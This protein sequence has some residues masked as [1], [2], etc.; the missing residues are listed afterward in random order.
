MNF[1]LKNG[2]EF[3]I[4]MSPILH[5]PQVRLSNSH[6]WIHVNFI[7][8]VLDH[9]E[10]YNRYESIPEYDTAIALKILDK[11]EDYAEI[12]EVVD[13]MEKLKAFI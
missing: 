13:K 6:Q 8:K 4:R 10:F 7:K 9:P 1:V 5:I 2:S 3:E 12:V 11:K